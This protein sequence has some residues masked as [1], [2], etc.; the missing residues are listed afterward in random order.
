MFI[1][2]RETVNR[3]INETI[4][5]YIVHDFIIKF[6]FYAYFSMWSKKIIYMKIKEPIPKYFVTKNQ[7]LLEIME[8]SA[9]HPLRLYP[10]YYRCIIAT[11]IA[12]IKLNMVLPI[13]IKK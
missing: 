7:L 10:K 3:I 12:R 1:L 4:T 13:R 2:D 11:E 5:S 6:L 9:D 8:F